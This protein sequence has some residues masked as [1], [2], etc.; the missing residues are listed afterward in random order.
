MNKPSLALFVALSLAVPA[1]CSAQVK[2]KAAKPTK[3]YKEGVAL[4][5]QYIDRVHKGGVWGGNADN[6]PFIMEHGAKRG[7]SIV[8]VH[9]LTDSPCYMRELAQVFYDR[10]YNVVG[11]RL[12]GHGTAPEDLQKATLAQ[13]QDDVN[14]GINTASILGNEVSVAGFS[15]GGALILNAV[16]RRQQ[17]NGP[18][19][20]LGDVYLFSPAIDLPFWTAIGVKGMCAVGTSVKGTPWAWGDDKTVEDNTCGYKKGALNGVCQLMTQIEDNYS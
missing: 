9:G 5:R 12:R 11:V 6:L 13:W 19:W 7:R 17:P 14:F 16:Y 3:E 1:L 2:E 20:N 18:K 15:T 10:G 4:Y 8:L